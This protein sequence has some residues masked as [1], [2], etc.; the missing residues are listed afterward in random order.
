MSTIITNTERTKLY[1]QLKHQLGAPIIG[2][3]L[4][5]EMLDSLLELA[6]LDY[7]MYVQDW[8]IENQWSS[9]YDI[10]IDEADLTRAFMT[11]SLDWETSFTYAYSKIVGLQAGGPWELKKDFVTLSAN[12]QIYQIPANREINEI[13]WYSRAELNESFVDPFLG[14]FGGLG[15]GM[16][17]GGGG[18]FA[19][20]GMVGSY[21]MMPANDLLL[22]MA[23]RNI[24]NRLISSELTYRLTA[25]PNGSKFL[26]LY[27]V[28]G[29]DFD[30]GN[31]EIHDSKCWY[32]YYDTGKDGRDACLEAN[33]DVVLLPSDVP[34]ESIK[35]VDL[36]PPAKAWIRRYFTALAK[37][38]LGRVRGK[39]SGA[40]KVPDSELTM[41]YSSLQT[42]GIDEKSKLTEELTSRLE[43][44]RQD[45]MMER[46]ANEAEN[47]NKALTYRPFQDPYNVI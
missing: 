8:L 36:N 2:V 29:G 16:G 46:K 44:L 30:F 1:T 35:Y 3:E 28:P 40:L 27:N 6:V 43:R 11:R 13:M 9:L 17:L 12:T 18:G 42:E 10:S 22:R 15:G 47:L 20:M 34:I 33:K 39:Y 37:E 32:W 38:T 45:S 4:E 41:D 19:Q 14:A 25:G 21:Y 7:G 5:D 31:R 24:K 26:H 23:D